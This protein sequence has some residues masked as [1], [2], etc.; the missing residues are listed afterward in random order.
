[1]Q[2]NGPDKKG[3]FH[4]VTDFLAKLH[5]NIEDISQNV[6]QGFLS[7]TFILDVRNAAINNDRLELE[8]K[9]LGRQHDMKFQLYSPHANIILKKMELYV[10]ITMGP[11]TVG[12]LANIS[13]ILKN[14]NANIMNIKIKSRDGWIFNQLV[15]DLADVEDIELLRNL[16][17]HKCDELSLSMTLQK[18]STYRRNK[19]LIAFDMDSTLVVGETIVEI[20]RE[21]GIEE[22]MDEET[23]KAM[24]SDINFEDSI[25][26]R[27]KLIK[28]AS[29]SMLEELAYKAVIMPGGEELIQ[30]LKENG[31]KIA[32]VSSGFSLF[33][34]IIK[35][36]L[37]LDFAFGNTL[38]F[39]DNKLTGNLLGDIIDGEAKWEIIA[40]ICDELEIPYEET[41]TV[42]DGSNDRIM[43][44]NSGLG[45]GLNSKEIASQV[46]DGRVLLNDVSKILL[47][48]GLS[49]TKID[50]FMDKMY[51]ENSQK[52][53]I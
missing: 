18:E 22:K 53:D 25:R 43:L 13:E 36:R 46:A 10:F 40:S 28:G 37:G 12:L 4:I 23:E 27:V 51:L 50:Q 33:A 44:K 39:N 35:E 5:I 24:H 2:V 42:G 49:D 26:S 14:A 17:R 7:I 1:M 32:L 16:L 29:K 20:A 8:L 30:T 47:M 19:R 11:D 52:I 45:I 34:E 15:L 6:L 48:L 21:M 9:K 3:F 31:F 41:V 38:E